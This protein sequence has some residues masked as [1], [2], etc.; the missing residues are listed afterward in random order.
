MASTPATE[1]NGG[2]RVM[3]TGKEQDNRTGE[4][5]EALR[6][7][8]VVRCAD[9]IHGKRRELYEGDEWVRCMNKEY[10]SMIYEREPLRLEDHLCAYG[11]RRT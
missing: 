10:W 4:E 7:S 6:S 5:C 9:C 3:S 11:K 1:R 8:D 2:D